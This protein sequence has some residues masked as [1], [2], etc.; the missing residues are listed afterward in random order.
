MTLISVWSV[1]A[2]NPSTKVL[3]VCDKDTAQALE[4]ARHPL[5]EEVDNIVPIAVPEGETSFR[6]RYIKTNLRHYIDG[7]FLY[8]DSDT[9]VRGDLSPVFNVVGDV[10]GVPNFN[11]EDPVFDVASLS[12]PDRGIYK[13]MEWKA[14]NHSY[15]NGGVLYFADTITAHNFCDVWHS[16]WKKMNKH[17][18]HSYDQASL[19]YAIQESGVSLSVLPHRFNAQVYRVPHC[20]RQASVW[21]FY[22]SQLKE[23]PRNILSYSLARYKEGTCDRELIQALSGRVHPWTC[24]NRVDD[25]ILRMVRSRKYLRK[26][27]KFKTKLG[28]ILSGIL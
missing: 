2:S 21:H 5:R 3:V 16:E 23:E 13:Q 1:R 4:R 14:P 24:A 17:T 18:G 15:I 27:M 8:L 10:A 9:L 12:P 11:A 22:T 28:N 25:M 6:N 26:Y 19:N 7:P 20:T